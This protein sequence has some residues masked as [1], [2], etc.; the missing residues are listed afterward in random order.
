M[1]GLLL[2]QPRVK[3]WRDRSGLF[4]HH[5]VISAFASFNLC[6]LGELPAENYIKGAHLA[7]QPKL[8]E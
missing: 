4:M 5:I 3:V 7:S 1:H 6:G 8:A 2:Q